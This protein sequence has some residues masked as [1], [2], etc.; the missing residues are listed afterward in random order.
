[1]ANVSKLKT[2][3]YKLF[4]NRA[5][6]WFLQQRKRFCLPTACADGLLPIYA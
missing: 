3:Q 1:M 2:W 6:I 5:K 4:R